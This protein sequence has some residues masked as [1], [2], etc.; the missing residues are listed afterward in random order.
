[1][2]RLRLLLLLTVFGCTA[3]LLVYSIFPPPHLD[4]LVLGVDSRGAEGWVAR[5]D[6]VMLVGI[7]PATLGVA[8]MSV[9][10]DLSVQVPD[11]GLQRINTV[12]VLGEMEAP[13]QGP[14]LTEAAVAES[15]GVTPERYVRLDFQGFV[16]LIDAVGGITINVEHPLIDYNYPTEDYNVT[17]VQF[18]AGPQ[19]MDGQRALVYARTRHADDDYRRADRQQ[20]VMR[21][22]L[23]KAINPI[24]WPGIVNALSRYVD[25]NLNA[26]DILMSLPPLLV[27]GARMERLIIDRDLISA[28]A[29]GVA[30]PDYDKIAPWLS[31]HFD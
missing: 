7:D 26:W 23:S 25:T 22:L 8:A 16:A 28:T 1:M 18:D 17:T 31:A 27:N 14:L 24:Y 12:N 20:Q 13:G 15:F 2:K 30:I 19:H 5:A 11:Y 4:I 29:E 3:S 9:P 21:A 6:S 10:R